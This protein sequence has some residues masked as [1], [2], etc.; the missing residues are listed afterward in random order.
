M[1][2]CLLLAGLLPLTGS[3]AQAQSVDE[4]LESLSR[5]EREYVGRHCL[6]KEY[7]E[8][9]AAYRDCVSTA[10]DARSTRASVIFDTLSFDDRYALQEVCAERESTGPD[11]GDG[12]MQACMDEQISRLVDAPEPTTP[13]PGALTPSERRDLADRCTTASNSV[14][15]YRRCMLDG[16]SDVALPGAMA[17]VDGSPAVSSTAEVSTAE[18]SSADNSVV[19]PPVIAAAELAPP[20]ESVIEL[21]Q[22]ETTDTLPETDVSPALEESIAAPDSDAAP[23]GA[24][25]TNEEPAPNDDPDSDESIATGNETSVAS[26][27]PDDAGLPPPDIRQRASDALARLNLTIAGL[28]GIERVVLG[29]AVALPLLLIAAWGLT[30]GSR[31]RAA[32]ARRYEDSLSVRNHQLSNRL[33]EKTGRHTGDSSYPDEY[34]DRQAALT[35]DAAALPDLFDDREH[36]TARGG[37]DVPSPEPM[38]RAKSER[39]L[40]VTLDATLPNDIAGSAS[41]NDEQGVPV[42]EGDPLDD[43]VGEGFAG[44]LDTSLD[45]RKGMPSK[46]PRAADRETPTT[47]TADS[48]DTS[49]KPSPVTVPLSA[50]GRWIESNDERRRLELAIEFLIYWM[51][52][53]DE[54]Y[55]PETRSRLLADGGNDG[56][57]HD[58]IKRR[59]LEQDINAFAD[60]VRWLQRNANELQRIQILDLLMVLLVSDRAMSPLQNTLLRYLSD[61]FG[62][63]DATLEERHEVAFGRP[64][65]TLP[66]VDL[67]AWWNRVS[68][69]ELLRWDART[70]MQLD[71]LDQYRSQ[72]GLP[73]DGTLDEA[74]IVEGFRW[75]ARRCHPHRFDALGDRERSLAERQYSKFE[76]ARD[77]LL[78]VTA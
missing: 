15:A 8:G 19:D 28:K 32:E 43:V 33:R 66:R 52:Y 78:G 18:F 3:L 9:A 31:A 55:D 17:N 20:S 73:M 71:P 49:A 51:A 46:D 14:A 57:P 45:V 34:D 74:Q 44:S 41:V 2:L 23:S 62:L 75:A 53:G 11:G 63:G 4:R 6:P 29:T 59:V 24:P 77:R 40:D 21:A 70:V 37:V 22:A 10:L 47:S 5:A 1:S 42:D 65:S 61:A 58:L 26:D 38:Q 7:E 48:A 68:E 69:D 25:L 30:R 27:S 13:D 16:A 39:D 35:G 64:M 76:E 56:D 54:R 50:F 12:R 60:T 67:M 36:H 72:L